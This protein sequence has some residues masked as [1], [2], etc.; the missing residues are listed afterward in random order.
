MASLEDLIVALEKSKEPVPVKRVNWTNIILIV[1]VLSLGGYLVYDKFTDDNIEPGPSFDTVAEIV[2]KQEN[3]Y[4]LYKSQTYDKLS[5]LVLSGEITNQEELMVNAQELLKSAREASL[6]ELDKL[7]NKNLP[8][9]FED[10]ET[11]ADY[12]K[13]KSK[14]FME[15]SK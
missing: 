2:E 12:L 13:E 9:T 8:V 6:G 4:S 10:K 7:D 15:A 11:V 14:G 1:L 5:E 3:L